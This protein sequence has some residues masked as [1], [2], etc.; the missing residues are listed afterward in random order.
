VLHRALTRPGIERARDQLQS[1]DERA[2]ADWLIAAG[3]LEE[4]AGLLRPTPRT[5][6]IFGIR[7]SQYGGPIPGINT[8]L[9]R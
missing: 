8:L 1:V 6:A 4:K 3:I 9:E 2:A 5:E 7:P